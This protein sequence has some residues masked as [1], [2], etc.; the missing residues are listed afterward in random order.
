MTPTLRLNSPASLA[1]TA[2]GG[3]SEPRRVEDDGTDY[4]VSPVV[5]VQEAV[6]RY[7]APDGGITRELLPADE[8]TATTNAWAGRPLLL[9]HP[10][11]PEGTPTV[12]QNGD[13]VNPAEIGEVRDPGVSDGALRAEAWI[14]LEEQGRHD[15]DLVGIVNA[16]EAGRIVETS[17]G[18]LAD[19][20]P[21][22]GRLNGE[23]YDAVQQ[24]LRPDHLAVFP[25]DGETG[26][27]SVAEGCGVGR[28][29]GLTERDMSNTDSVAINDDA[30]ETLGRRVLNA[31]GMGDEAPAGSQAGA[32]ADCSCQDGDVTT[33]A[34]TTA[35]DTPSDSETDSDSDADA[36]DNEADAGANAAD[37]EPDPDPD[38]DPDTTPNDSQSTSDPPMTDETP[39][40]A[41]EGDEPTE[42]GTEQTETDSE[43]TSDESESDGGIEAESLA[44]EAGTDADADALS[45]IKAEIQA[46]REQNEELRE[47]I[48][49]PQRE[50]Q[51][52]A[53][54]VVANEFGVDPEDVDLDT[55][56]A[57]AVLNAQ[58]DQPAQAQA[59]GQGQAT[60]NMAAIPGRVERANASDDSEDIPSGG[61]SNWA[62]E[63]GGD[64]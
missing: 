35:N 31:L 44:V 42:A 56:A 32:E 48:E 59:Q 18:Y 21:A 9:R 64:D 54:E 4:L 58:R 1:P 14:N 53:A 25:V 22:D 10:E 2:S 62:A 16:L 20:A 61:Y 26:N 27:C 33:N 8:L 63:N 60:A 7:P 28:A 23:S 52:E 38:A 13:A 15:G 45:E 47:E 34:D 30:A 17:T 3:E 6:Y 55:E 40:S 37:G 24:N 11:D 36:T 51:Q 49:A 46:L 29:N 41:D 43:T 57:Q 50:A 12:I 39:E 5:A 19:R